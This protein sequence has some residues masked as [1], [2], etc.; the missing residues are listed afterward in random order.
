MKDNNDI[1][2]LQE[3]QE[4]YDVQYQWALDAIDLS[5][6]SHWK[7][8]ETDPAGDF[9]DVKVNLSVQE[10]HG[11]TETLRL[12]TQYELSVGQDYWSGTVAKIFGPQEI[13]MMASRF[14][15]AET[16]HSRFYNEINKVLGYDTKEFATAYKKDPELLSRMNFIGAATLLPTDWNVVDLMKSVASFSLI[17][18]VIL[19]SNFAFLKHFKSGGK[20]LLSGVVAGNNYSISD[21]SEHCDAGTKLF[22]TLMQEGELTDLEHDMLLNEIM[23]LAD[24][25][26]THEKIITRRIFEK[27][28]IEGITQ[29]GL[30]SFINDRIR[31]VLGQLGVIKE[32]LDM[33]YPIHEDR[34]IDKWFYGNV[35]GI[36]QTDVFNSVSNQYSRHWNKLRF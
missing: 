33:R 17:E 19:F 10:S 25:A 13:K 8:D 4:F 26:Q 23:D 28:E 16:T 32:V 11:L 35:N 30:D 36:K 34:T 12:F 20:N 22:S 31:L 29:E 9:H 3:K 21:E 1:Q 7:F 27:G 24:I 2:I 14:S 18:G 15:Y 5:E 6:K